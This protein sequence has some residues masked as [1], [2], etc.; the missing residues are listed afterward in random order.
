MQDQIY[1]RSSIVKIKFQPIDLKCQKPTEIRSCFVSLD[2]RGFLTYSVDFDAN[3]FITEEN[4]WDII[5]NLQKTIIKKENID[6]IELSFDGENWVVFFCTP[7]SEFLIAYPVE[8]LEEAKH[9]FNEI[10]TWYFWE[11]EPLKFH[12]PTWDME[13]EKLLTEQTLKRLR[14]LTKDQK[15]GE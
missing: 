2:Y 5:P 15:D 9:T 3:Q 8:K 7:R 10:R 13:Y 1:Q 12:I 14:E 4:R 11:P 6:A